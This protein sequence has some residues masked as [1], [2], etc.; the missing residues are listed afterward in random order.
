MLVSVNIVYA[1]IGLTVYKYV[2][3]R[4]CVC[5][6]VREWMSVRDIYIMLIQT[7]VVGRCFDPSGWIYLTYPKKSFQHL[8]KKNFSPLPWKAF[9]QSATD[10]LNFLCYFP[11]YDEWHLP[12]YTG[13]GNTKGHEKIKIPIAK[14]AL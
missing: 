11:Q 2:C 8:K 9:F 1:I 10:G 4:M 13:G 6:C 14:T 3:M 7:D 5:A 12:P